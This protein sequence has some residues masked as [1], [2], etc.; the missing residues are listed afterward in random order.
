[1]RNIWRLLYSKSAKLSS[2]IL[3]KYCP[4]SRWAMI[5]AWIWVVNES[6]NPSQHFP[7]IMFSLMPSV[8]DNVSKSPLIPGHA[9]CLSFPSSLAVTWPSDWILIYAVPVKW[10][11]AAPVWT[12]GG[13]PS[14]QSSMF[15]FFFPFSLAAMKVTLRMILES[16]MKEPL[17]VCFLEWLCETDPSFHCNLLP[18]LL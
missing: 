8:T 6:M 13:P 5:M 10:C 9:P 4:K 18:D 11:P 16:K 15:T 14:V 12:D 17:S 1:M 7:I 3:E 2:E